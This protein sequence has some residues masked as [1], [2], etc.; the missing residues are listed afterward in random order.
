VLRILDLE[1]DLRIT[2]SIT[3]P[4]GLSDLLQDFAIVVL[5][6]KPRDL[7]EFAAK[8]FTELH[9]RAQG[10]KTEAQ[11]EDTEKQLSPEETLNVVITEESG[12]M[13]DEGISC[14]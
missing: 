14:L 2:M 13:D 6:E 9:E 10:G 1:R 7:L 8:Y 4:E 5:R 3:V 12:D 11:R